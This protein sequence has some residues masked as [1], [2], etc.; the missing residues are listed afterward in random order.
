LAIPV[1]ITIPSIA[2]T[3]KEHTAQQINAAIIIEVNFPNAFT[4]PIS[5]LSPYFSA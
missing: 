3:R 1:W 2:D 4:G 5:I